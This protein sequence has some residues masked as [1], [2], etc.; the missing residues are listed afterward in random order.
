METVRNRRE[1]VYNTQTDSRNAELKRCVCMLSS[2]RSILVPH[3]YIVLAHPIKT[4]DRG[5][6]LLTVPW[7]AVCQE[8]GRILCW[9]VVMCVWVLTSQG[10]K[11]VIVRSMGVVSI[12]CA[13]ER[14]SISFCMTLLKFRS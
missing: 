4:V 13:C 7:N 9:D 10:N 5:Y 8:I 1:Q 14:F 12:A 2:F 6:V 11:V 3:V